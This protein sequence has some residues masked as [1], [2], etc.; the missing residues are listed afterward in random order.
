MT[1]PSFLNITRIVTLM[2]EK[3]MNVPH[4]HGEEELSQNQSEKILLLPQKAEIHLG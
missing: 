3:E 2:L 1:C 4:H